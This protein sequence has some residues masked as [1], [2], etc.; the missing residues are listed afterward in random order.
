[1]A[2]RAYLI[3]T[4][5]EKS[6]EL[7]EANNTIPLFWFTLLNLDIIEKFEQRIIDYYHNYYAN[8]EEEEGENEVVNIEIPKQT[9][10]KNVTTGKR[11]VEENYPDRVNLYNDFVKYLEN[12]FSEDDILELNIVEMANFCGIDFLFEDIKNVIDSISGS[13][14]IVQSYFGP[15]DSV[16]SFV[17]DDV[18]LDNQFKDYS[19]DYLEYRLNEKKERELRKKE[20]AK[21]QLKEKIKEK[22]KNIFMCVGGIAFIG[23]SILVIVSGNYFGGIV[24]II[25]GGISLLFG[26]L[27]L[28]G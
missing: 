17:G 19:V 11:F 16:Y 1:M 12:K 4:S 27:N 14:Y 25:F 20:L 8:E 26:I 10:M 28:K 7:F 23:A 18:F 13:R 24:G 3:K 6:E 15:A 2:N 5:K 21:Q 9:F 22:F